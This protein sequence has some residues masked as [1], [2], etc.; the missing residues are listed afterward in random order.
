MG[1]L[2]YR[3]STN[4]PLS[5]R[6]SGLLL[7]SIGFPPIEAFRYFEKKDN[8]LLGTSR[9]RKLDMKR[10]RHGT[11]RTRRWVI[12]LQSTLLP[13]MVILIHFTLG[14]QI[15]S[16]ERLLNNPFNMFCGQDYDEARQFCHLTDPNKSLPCPN[17]AEDDCP[18]N[19]PCWEI[20]EE[21]L[22]PPTPVPEPTYKP[23]FPS[24]TRSPTKYPTRSPLTARSKIPGDHY[25]CG[26]G[27]DNLFDCAVNCPNGLPSE[28]PHGQLCYFNTPCD[29]RLKATEPTEKAELDEKQQWVGPGKRNFC[30]EDVL[31]A[32]KCTRERHCPSGL[33]DECPPGLF[34]WNDVA[35]CN[36]DELPTMNPTI[37]PEPT[38]MPS[39][40]PTTPRP[41][42]Y[43]TTPDPAWTPEPTAAPWD[44]DDMRNFFFCGKSWGDASKRCYRRCPSGFHEECADGEECFAQAACKKLLVDVPT[45]QPSPAPFEGTKAPTSSPRP[46]GLTVSPT[47]S[48]LA[49]DDMRRYFFCG[50]TWSDASTRCY[51]RCTSGYHT[52]CPEDQECFAQA[53]CKK[54][55]TPKPSAA[56]SPAPF[57]GTRAPT[58]S[59]RPTNVPTDPQPTESPVLNPTKSPENDP[60]DKPTTPYP[61]NRPTYAP[62]A[63]DPCPAKDH[64]RSSRGFCGP[65]KHYCNAKS[66]WEASCGVPTDPPQ[67]QA[68]TTIWPS[69]SPSFSMMPTK[70]TTAEPTD[71]PTKKSNIIY[72]LN[73]PAPT[74]VITRRPTE[75]PI[76]DTP[77]PAYVNPDDREFEDGDPLATFFCGTSWNQAITE[78]PH[79]CPSGEAEECPRDGK[80]WSCYAFTPCQGIGTNTKTTPKPTWEPTKRPTPM[81][82][83][84]P[85]TVEHHWNTLNRKQPTDQPV[86]IWW[87][88]VP[89]P[90]PSY[91]PTEDQCIGIPCDYQGECRSRL[92]FC[93]LGIV[94]CNSVSSWVPS[95][96]GGKG[97]V[98][99]E[100]AR[101]ASPNTEPTPAPVTAWEAWVMGSKVDTDDA[102]SDAALGAE[103]IV[104][105]VEEEATEAKQVGADNTN[106][107][108]NWGGDNEG[109]SDSGFDDEDMK[110]W[111]FDRSSACL[112]RAPISLGAT[113]SIFICF[114]TYI[115]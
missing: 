44:A 58:S 13:A 62:C 11:N 69:T 96:G 102:T 65:G 38:E 31:D 42:P 85:T 74:V 71:E 32:R 22:P 20:K 18:Y 28:C 26:I 100:P 104:E 21:C 89:T 3:G 45:E 79:R 64:C 60:T 111:I 35:G 55:L 73:T 76:P 95:C 98:H 54:L 112:C 10:I 40:S 39:P 47:M 37:S 108:L 115:I 33:S 48:P 70:E 6:S 4:Q 82:S 43:P 46:S 105:E 24:V 113:L 25:F 86:K 94:Y 51:K 68:P 12:R 5:P 101:T 16:T 19:L 9:H 81:P 66:I 77:K 41:T 92:G 84:L 99:G 78:C 90:R 27:I 36:I 114:A 61:T 7:R 103:L 75:R 59:P 15:A 109:T 107:W 97:L 17:G 23:T 67:S 72:H 14:A 57:S 56:P 93:G 30:G 87:T 88:P 8:M 49:K 91:S 106:P 29:A 83:D 63:G 53:A 2:S 52:E 80:K 1:K 34:C 50:T 110:W